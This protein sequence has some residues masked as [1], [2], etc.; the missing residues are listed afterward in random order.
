[1]FEWQAIM[2]AGFF[3]GL[4]FGSIIAGTAAWLERR[5]EKRR[6][7]VVVDHYARALTLEIANG[8]WSEDQRSALE[9][10]ADYLADVRE[11]IA[12]HYPV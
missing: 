3:V 12:A 8:G 2:V 9:H 1:M 10:A 4:G 7:L 5:S 11:E 6:A